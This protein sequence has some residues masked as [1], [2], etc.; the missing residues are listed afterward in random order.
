[1]RQRNETA[2]PLQE[3]RENEN[4]ARLQRYQAAWAAYTGDPIEY[5]SGNQVVE[6]VDALTEGD[7]VIVP[8]EQLVVNK[9]RS[10][11]FGHGIDFEIEEEQD[12]GSEQSDEGEGESEAQKYLDR[13]WRY[14]RK[15]TLLLK[16]STNGGVFGHVF[17]KLQPSR[18]DEDIPRLIVMDTMNLSVEWDDQDIEAVTSYINTW[19][20]FDAD[21]KPIVRREVVKEVAV[22]SW[23]VQQFQADMVGGD[24]PG[25]DAF[26]A[27]GPALPWPHDWP[28]I[29]D[30][31]NTPIPNE[32]Y[33]WSDI[34][35]STRRVNRAI[36]R[37]MSDMN[38][39]VRLW[40]HPTLVIEG[41]NSALIREMIKAGEITFATDSV[42]VLPGDPASGGAKLNV[43]KPE[44][45]LTASIELYK[46]LRE[47]FH[48]ITRTPEVATGK[49]DQVGA[50]SGVALQILYGPLMEATED[51]RCTYGDMLEELN[52]RIL[53]Y[54]GFGEDV[55]VH[56]VW[57]DPLPQDEQAESASLMAD[58][59]IG[60]SKK[61]LLQ[62]RGYD[63]DK[64]AA[65]R[66][67]EAEEALEIQ[68]RM[69]DSGISAFGQTDQ[70]P[71]QER[72]E[73]EEEGDE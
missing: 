6:A 40:G 67:E 73:D 44:A 13:V 19:N 43:V 20:T 15:K 28:P 70:S 22:G 54:G 36:D 47:V 32:F 35:Q 31:Q 57:S 11:L 3:L 46:K 37:L 62:K 50:I 17:I 56:N 42:Q 63:P 1:M 48:E 25:P 53:D 34:E 41:G 58:H 65:N 12:T 45:D 38:R 49:T 18:D 16:A 14:N 64:E 5:D 60:A 33:G 21:G 52:R 10:F 55:Q 8:Y 71:Q 66:M 69:I 24:G 61:T 39:I 59:Q 7:S 29:I 27:I 51:K 26:T 68:Q 30:C 2:L 9:S 23:T 72:N 4:R